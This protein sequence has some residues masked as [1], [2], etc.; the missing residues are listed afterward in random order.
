MLNVKTF[1]FRML[2]SAVLQPGKRGRRTACEDFCSPLASKTSKRWEGPK[3]EENRRLGSNANDTTCVT[4]TGVSSLE[5]FLVT[6]LAEVVLAGVDH[7][8]AAHDPTNE[9]SETRAYRKIIIIRD[10][11]LG[12][13]ER[14]VLGRQADV[15]DAAGVALHVSEI[16]DVLLLILGRAVLLAKGVEV[17]PCDEGG[18]VSLAHVKSTQDMTKAG[19]LV[20]FRC[21]VPA[22]VHLNKRHRA[23]STDVKVAEKEENAPVGVVTELAVLSRQKKKEGRDG[24]RDLFVTHWMWNP[25]RALGSLPEI[26]P[27]TTT[28]DF[29]SA[30]RDESVHTSR[31][32]LS[33][34]SGEEKCKLTGLLERNDAVD[35]GV[36]LENCDSLDHFVLYEG[37]EC[38]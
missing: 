24:I 7:N 26:S 33:P 11:R 14:K 17:R 10:A 30:E 15:D 12:A 13:D 18:C 21:D 38:C 31:I 32:K 28:G 6:A 35:L 3:R 4:A 27:F 22:D 16:A 29:S 9:R 36:T 2:S 19:T 34:P 25:R 5:A 1:L 8:G 23:F 20:V 37:E